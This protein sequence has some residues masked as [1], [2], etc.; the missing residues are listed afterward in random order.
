MHVGHNIARLRNY[1]GIKQEDMANRLHMSQQNYSLIEKA[2]KVKDDV[3][4]KIATELEYDAEF[5]KALPDT[6]HVYSSHQSG[7]NVINYEFNPIEKIIELYERLLQTEKE[8]NALQD[9]LLK[10]RSSARRQSQ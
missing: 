3:L 8:K 1:R 2:G 10:T 5:I 4:Q 7:G 6:P 9:E